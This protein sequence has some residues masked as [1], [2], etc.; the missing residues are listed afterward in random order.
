MMMGV[1]VNVLFRETEVEACYRRPRR[2]LVS[3]VAVG[4]SS[5]PS[6]NPLRSKQRKRPKDDGDAERSGVMMA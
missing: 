6:P 2:I 3:A 5:S 4:I 1:D